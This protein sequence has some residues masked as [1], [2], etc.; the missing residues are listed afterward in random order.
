MDISIRLLRED[1]LVTADHI[2]RLAFGT[3]T[4]DP[5]P[6][7][8]S[9]DAAYM[10]RWFIDS[11]AAFAAEVNGQL[12]GSN[13]AINRGSFGFFGPLTIHPDFWGHGIAQ[14]LIEAAM[15]RF[16][17]W[18]I[19]QVGL[20]TFS[21]S[22][23]H[24]SLYQ[25]FGFYPRFLN[26][27]VSKKVLPSGKMLQAVRYS[28]LPEDKRVKF[29]KCSYEMTSAIYDGLDLGREI[30]SVENLGLGDTVFLWDNAELVGFAVCHYGKGTEAGSDICYIRFGAVRPRLRAREIFEQLLQECETLSEL[31]GMSRLIGGMS[32]ARQE[33]YE[34]MLAFGFR[35]ERL[36]IAMHK[37]NEP[38]FSCPGVYLIDDWR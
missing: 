23:M 21:N 3:F 33:A 18:G 8:Y 36:G 34:K 6:A 27:L 10:K 25:K 11:S 26:V 7:N 24:L 31:Q 4:H 19:K 16:Q 22:P 12:V 14:Q 38:A 9:G 37:P 15:Q 29:L 13:F 30:Q 17:E 2:F 5:N 20:F 28:Q 1:D 32:T 35:I